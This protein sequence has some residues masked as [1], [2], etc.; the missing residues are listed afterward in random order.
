M[1]D[2]ANM[3][4]HEIIDRID[5]RNRR[6]KAAS[7][8]FAALLLVG[9]V[10]LLVLGLQTLQ[11]VNTQLSSQKKLLTNQQQTLS[12]IT[13]SGKQRTAQIQDLQNHIDCI[14]ELLRQPNRASLT[15]KDLNGC[16]FDTNGNIISGSS[17]ANNNGT[18]QKPTANSNNNSGG[19]NA[20]APSS[21]SGNSLPAQTPQTGVIPGTVNSL[22]CPVNLANLTC[23]K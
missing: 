21:Q 17:G 12:A 1:T 13:A 15:L 16:Q 2:L 18:T 7:V 9:L 4:P 3:A 10:V 20:P 5:D 11:G 19:T 22:F 14:V 8:V 23:N 6:F